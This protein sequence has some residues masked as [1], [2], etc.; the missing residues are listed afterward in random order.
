[1]LLLW[2]LEREDRFLYLAAILAGMGT[3]VKRE[4]IA[5]LIIYGIL[6]VLMLFQRKTFNYNRLRAG[7]K[8][9]LPCIVLALIFPVFKFIHHADSQGI[10]FDF[11][12]QNFQ[13]IPVILKQFFM[14]FFLSGNWNLVWILL[15]LRLFFIPVRNSHPI[16][17]WGIIAISLFAGLLFL[18]FLFTN[19]FF[20]ISERDTTLSRLILHFFPLAT[21]AIVLWPAPQFDKG[22]TS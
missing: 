6:V 20:W 12:W 4:G 15:I 16:F 21:I 18:L 13:R 11:S 10:L 7:A 9:F 22:K 17:K 19:A 2:Q 1:M 5:Y 14:D 3:F 8:F